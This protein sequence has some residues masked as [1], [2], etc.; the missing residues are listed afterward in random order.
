MSIKAKWTIYNTTLEVVLTDD[1]VFALITILLLD[2]K[3][4]E[5]MPDKLWIYIELIARHFFE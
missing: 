5:L 3:N 2:K 4:V 1:S